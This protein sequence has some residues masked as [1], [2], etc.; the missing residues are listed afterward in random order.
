MK[1]PNSIAHQIAS[2]IL[3]IRR[4]HDEAITEARRAISLDPND[5]NGH[6]IMAFGLIMADRA[7]EAIYFA[8]KARQLD[9]LNP[10]RPLGLMGLASFSNGETEEAIEF[11]ERAL[12]NNPGL[13]REKA[14]LTACYALLRKTEKAQAAAESFT[15]V[16][17]LSFAKTN[18]QRIM[19]LFPFKNLQ[20]SDRFADGLIKAGL[21]VGLGGYYK[22]SKEN[23]LTGEEIK[24]LLFGRKVAGKLSGAPGWSVGWSKDG[25][26]KLE[27]PYSGASE[28]GR[29]WVDGDMI[30]NDFP[31]FGAWWVEGE[32]CGSIYRNPDGKSE[33]KNE[34]LM[35]RDFGIRSFSPVE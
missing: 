31:V 14:V 28:T 11:I 22:I 30:C 6:L 9:P 19:F 20:V 15:D 33:L 12:R 2:Q 10:A 34:Y 1:N 27:D 13:Y 16:K 35:L 5:P 7:K 23:R 24:G 25:K 4:Q 8:K 18:L 29:S 17:Y 32:H 3:L 21:Y 26:A